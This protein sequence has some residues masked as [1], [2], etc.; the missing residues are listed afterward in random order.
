[1]LVRWPATLSEC[2]TIF[3]AASRWDSVGLPQGHFKAVYFQRPRAFG[4]V[5][6][7][8]ATP[9]FCSLAGRFVRR[10]DGTLLTDA[11]QINDVAHVFSHDLI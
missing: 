6:P 1:M 2:W 8:T 10:R 3:P 5:A 7:G 9:G 4:R 11:A